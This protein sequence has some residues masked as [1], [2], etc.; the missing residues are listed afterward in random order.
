MK[1]AGCKFYFHI[2]D[3]SYARDFKKVAF[4]ERNYIKN[5]ML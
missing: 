3:P 1:L 2:V 5:F 4:Q